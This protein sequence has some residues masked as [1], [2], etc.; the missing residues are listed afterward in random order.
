M[1]II[2]EPAFKL[3]DFIFLATFLFFLLFFSCKSLWLRKMAWSVEVMFLFG[4]AIAGNS[5][6]LF[7][8]LADRVDDGYGRCHD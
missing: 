1:Q 3:I 2:I 8:W 6:M 5:L 7:G 4:G